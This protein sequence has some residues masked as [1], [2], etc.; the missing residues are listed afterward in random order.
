MLKLREKQF[1][2]FNSPLS[3]PAPTPP[4][5]SPQSKYSN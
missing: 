2:I 3:S 1:K 5:P 4:H